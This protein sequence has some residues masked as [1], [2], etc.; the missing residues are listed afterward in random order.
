MVIQ[1][2]MRFPES[3][4]WDYSL[5]GYA[6]P[7]VQKA[8]LSLQESYGADV[9]ILFF[10][11]WTASNNDKLRGETFEKAKSVVS[12]WH[13]EVVLP[14][15]IIRQSLKTDS[16]GAEIA[17]VSVFRDR[18]KRIELESEH[19]E[20]LMLETCKIDVGLDGVDL[21]NRRLYATQG[22]CSYLEGLGA[23]LND[24]DNNCVKDFVFGTVI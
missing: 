11:T 12:K 10:I 2:T 1:D 13:N 19:I 16:K 14:L 3:K 17:L 9:N 22:I 5:R 24:G 21:V 8:S 18:I 20:Q 4:F 15:R 23:R 6:N 7:S